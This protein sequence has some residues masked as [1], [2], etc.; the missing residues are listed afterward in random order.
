[1]SG[2]FA[3]QAFAPSGGGLGWGQSVAASRHVH[4]H[5]IRVVC[6]IP[7]FPRKRGK[8]PKE[9]VAP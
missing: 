1:M 4:V 8:E 5:P 9:K 7:T 6:P 3:S 2:A